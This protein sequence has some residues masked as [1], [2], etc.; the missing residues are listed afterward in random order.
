M[1]FSYVKGDVELKI[2]H[3][4]SSLDF[5]GVETRATTIAKY[6]NF[7]N[8]ALPVFCAISKG[9][10]AE[11]VIMEQGCKVEVLNASCKIPSL[12]AFLKLLIFFR[13]EKPDVV[14][15]HGAEANFHGILAA[16][17]AGVPVRIGE[18]IGIPVHSKSAKRIFKFIYFLS[19]HVVAISDSVKAW[20]IDS[21]EVPL[22]KVTRIYNPVEVEFKKKCVSDS[23]RKFRISF[24]GRLEPVKNPLALIMAVSLLKKKKVPIELWMIGDGSLMRDCL[25]LISELEVS[26][27]VIMHGYS[28]DPSSLIVQSDLYVQPSIT[29]GFGIAL[30]EAMLCKVPVLA[31]SVGGA[32]EIIRHGENGWLVDNTDGES[33]SLAIGDIWNLREH[34]NFFGAKSYDSVC[35]RFNPENYINDL[36]SLYETMAN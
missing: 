15:A 4:F 28:D 20:L 30:V 33:L 12:K 10:Q 21:G 17:F 22:E 14:H 11:S 19:S 32:P 8:G 2:V 7:K 9:G 6:S 34:L 25:S 24:V 3:V 35:D 16:Y 1:H 27:A 13:Q 36:M 26:D 5:G 29:E 18:E 23:N 31:T